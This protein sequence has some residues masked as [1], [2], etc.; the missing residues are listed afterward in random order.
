[1]GGAALSHFI[2]LDN[3][4]TT[5]DY[6]FFAFQVIHYDW[7]HG[8]LALEMHPEADGPKPLSNSEL[9]QRVEEI[10]KQ[11]YLEKDLPILECTS[12]AVIHYKLSKL[13]AAEREEIDQTILDAA[14]RMDKKLHKKKPGNHG[15]DDYSKSFG[16]TAE[17]TKNEKEA[18]DLFR[19][20]S[21][22]VHDEVGNDLPGLLIPNCQHPAEHHM[23]RKDGK[24]FKYLSESGC[25]VYFHSVTKDLVAVKPDDYIEETH[26][27]QAHHEEKIVDLSNGLPKIE[28]QDLQ[29]EIDRIVKDLRKTPLIIDTSS[30]SVARTFYTYKA[31]LEDLSCLIVPF[32]KSGLKKEEIMERCRKKLVSALKTGQRFVLYL[33]EVTIEHADFKTKL[34]KKVLLIVISIPFLNI[35]LSVDRMY[36]RKKC[37]LMQD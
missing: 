31:H 32:G 8:S 23:L 12:P 36:S 10:M 5:H 35:L 19:G 37:L 3:Q 25:Y 9:Y 11:A 29:T 21:D 4:K 7:N 26:E 27:N 6:E 34:C 30:N 16:G 15:A 24:W 17:D 14:I 2:N 20:A 22:K 1:M 28:F 13:S 33:G 18:A